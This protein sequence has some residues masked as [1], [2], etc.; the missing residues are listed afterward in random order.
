M[1]DYS[2]GDFFL[3]PGI[4]IKQEVCDSNNYNTSASVPIPAKRLVDYHDMAFDFD[5]SQSPSYQDINLMSDMQVL[6]LIN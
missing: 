2:R 6:T 3:D 1:G 5:S 4:T